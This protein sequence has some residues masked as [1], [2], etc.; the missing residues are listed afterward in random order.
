MKP[1]FFSSAILLLFLVHANAQT[2]SVSGQVSDSITHK[3]ISGAT[4]FINKTTNFAYTDS[5]GRFR[6]DSLTNSSATIVCYK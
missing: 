1:V 4:V 3:A 5:T 6:F 2:F